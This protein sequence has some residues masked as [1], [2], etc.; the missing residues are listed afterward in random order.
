MHPHIVGFLVLALVYSFLKVEFRV[1]VAILPRSKR[2]TPSLYHHDLLDSRPLA[3]PYP[4]L[5]NLKD[6]DPANSIRDMSDL[7]DV[8]G[9]RKHN[10]S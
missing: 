10:E 6:I 9:K 4:I 5:G 7:A 3:A 1:H 8:C 2:H